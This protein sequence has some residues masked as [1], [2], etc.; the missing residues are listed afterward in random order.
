MLIR[1]KS[2][3]ILNGE[4]FARLDALFHYPRMSLLLA[5]IRSF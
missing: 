1:L 2:S 3:Q 5:S 4:K